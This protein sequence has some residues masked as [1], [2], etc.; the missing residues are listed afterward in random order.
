[1][2]A[3]NAGNCGGVAMYLNSNCVPFAEKLTCFKYEIELPLGEI[4]IPHPRV[5]DAYKRCIFTLGARGG[6]LTGYPRAGEDE[7]DPSPT[8]TEFY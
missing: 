3:F 8:P 7:G 1:M 2:S 5:A 6:P 4:M